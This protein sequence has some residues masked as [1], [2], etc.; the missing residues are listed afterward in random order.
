MLIRVGL[1]HRS[2]LWNTVFAL[3]ALAWLG[4]RPLEAASSDEEIVAKINGFV[5]QGWSDSSVT[6]SERADD[7]EYARR[8]SLDIVG[9]IP[10]YQRLVQFLNDS[11]PDK[12]ARLVDELLDDPD[13]AE[14][15][16]TIWGN[17]LIGR[18]QNRRTNRGVL[19]RWIKRQFEKN[20]RYDQFVYDLISAEGNSEQNGAVGF[21]A[22]HL[23]ENAVPATAITARLFLGLQVQCT[24]CH[25]H[26]FNDWKQSQFWGM[27]A[28]FRG[29]RRQGMG[30]AQ[31]ND[32]DLTDND[33]E[34]IVFFEK[35]S[36][37]MEAIT[38]QFVDGTLVV[39]ESNDSPRKQLAKL[40]IDPSKPYLGR[41]AVNRMWAHFLGSGFT[42]PIDDMGPHNPPSHP[43]LV[44]YLAQ[45]F[46]AAG[47]DQKRLIRW[48]AASDAYNLTSRFHSRHDPAPLAPALRGEGPG[49]RGPSAPA[50]TN[51]ETTGN[52]ADDPAS[53]QTPLFSHVYVKPFTA[54]Q[55]YDSLLVATEAH[56]AGR[57]FEQSEKQRDEWLGQFVRTFGTDENDEASSFNGTVPQAL[58]M[59]NGELVRNALSGANGSFL[60]RVLE[61]TVSKPDDATDKN[62]S[63]RT[64][65][66]APQ[67]KL[68]GIKPPKTIPQK[69]EVLYLTALARKPSPAELSALDKAFHNSGNRDPILGLQDVFWALL[70][71]NEFITN[72]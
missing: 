23:N 13:Y 47:Y 44:D 19:E 27:N 58:V 14:Q 21:L 39:G 53:G 35:R 67:P 3:L 29:T 1:P 2:C 18:A 48:I 32:F 62:K 9:H 5:K 61:G 22:A 17:L 24:Q 68:T 34:S 50:A 40:V 10:A 11:S 8:V 63:A 43:E 69:I 30:N 41:A 64:S 28:F 16:S 60:R 42:R 37:I 36:G 51:E 31:R 15:F 7:G 52:T 25:N 38:R 56:K 4:E 54:E 20:A 6:P 71:S 70:N 57:N 26:P 66:S 59:M 55:L 72:H 46:Q 33:A 45:E 65:A 49:V 12:R